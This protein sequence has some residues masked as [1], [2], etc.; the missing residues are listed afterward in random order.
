M[1]IEE[2]ARPKLL[3]ISPFMR[4]T[5]GEMTSSEAAATSVIVV[6]LRPLELPEDDGTKI[7]RI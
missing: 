1:A 5:V 6:E 2:V 4:E 3:E 7:M